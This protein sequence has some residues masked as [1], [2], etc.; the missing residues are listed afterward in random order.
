MLLKTSRFF[1]RTGSPNI[2]TSK[3]NRYLR[4]H[5]ATLL[6][7]GYTNYDHRHSE[8]IPEVQHPNRSPRV[9]KDSRSI[10]S[11]D[12]VVLKYTNI[13]NEIRNVEPSSSKVH[14]TNF[15]NIRFDNENVPEVHG[16]YDSIYGPVMPV[17]LQEML[18]GKDGKKSQAE[19]ETNATEYNADYEDI[20]YVSHLSVPILQQ[21]GEHARLN[22]PEV[23]QERETLTGTSKAVEE[24]CTDSNFVDELYFGAAV[25]NYSK[26]DDSLSTEINIAPSNDTTVT[27]GLNYIDECVFGVSISRFDE[28]SSSSVNE[29]THQFAPNDDDKYQKTETEQ[30]QDNDNLNYIDNHFFKDSLQSLS[31]ENSSINNKIQHTEIKQDTKA[32]AKKANEDI[33]LDSPITVNLE[34]NIEYANLTYL[35]QK[36]KENEVLHKSYTKQNDKVKP[37]VQNIEVPPK[38]AFD[39][40][41]KMR[42][43]LHKKEHDIHPDIVGT[44]KSYKKILSL[45]SVKSKENFTKFEVLKTLKNSVI[46]D[47]DDIVGL[48]KPY[49]IAMHRGT[50]GHQHILSD[51]L[52]DL[53]RY[54]KAD[55]LYPVHRLDSNTTGVLLMARTP[56]MADILKKMFKECQLKKTYWAITKGIP[57][58]LQG[59]I[60]IPIADGLIEGKHRMV[61][62]PDIKGIKN[63]TSNSHLAVTSFKVLA[64]SNSAAFVELSP[65]TGV[66]HQLRVH[67]GFGMSCPILG[68][69]KYSH[70]KKLAPQRLPGDILD[71]LR[72]KQSRVRDL[73]MFLHSRSVL[74]PEIMD[75]KNVFIVARLPAFFNKTLSVLELNKHKS[76]VKFTN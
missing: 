8:R 44:N 76:H 64:S 14:L 57:N 48:Y 50:S 54:L 68:D 10:D 37:K 5:C 25:K 2:P 38:S 30:Q 45:L 74:I 31:K 11:V 33:I 28:H 46:Y 24:H 15:G 41:V 72:I 52:P 65:M 21:S 62:S 13:I 59:V 17:G 75:G 69:H 26:S 71:H 23:K 61:L 56:S 60:D 63:P 66:K 4:T 1:L 6:P 32:L 58:P 7:R 43:D 47:K 9:H 27:A 18:S 53:A 16:Q 49:G 42:K 35:T 12:S 29:H 40:I 51:Y 36:P 3:V 19:D 22:K 70:L 55:E 67:L 73:P 39:Y 34:N 20:P